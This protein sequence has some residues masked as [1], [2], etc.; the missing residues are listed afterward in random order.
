MAHFAK[1]DETNKVLQVVVVSNEITTP[2]GV[3]EDEQLGIS[4]LS[5]QRDGVW[6][7][8]S[9][10]DNLRKQYAGIGYTFNETSDVFVAE[11]P[12]PSWSLDENHDW[13]PPIPCPEG[14]YS[15]NESTQS[16]DAVE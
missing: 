5:A 8:T 13:E 4:F 7:Q 9:Y 15:W 1:L 16:W 12:F 10:N 14:S 3:N 2:D 11:Q 6:K